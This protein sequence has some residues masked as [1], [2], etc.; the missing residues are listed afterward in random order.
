MSSAPEGPADLAEK[1]LCLGSRALNEFLF[2]A[3]YSLSMHLDMLLARL[4]LQLMP[5]GRIRRRFPIPA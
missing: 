2:Q 3:K 5:C 4:V 1:S